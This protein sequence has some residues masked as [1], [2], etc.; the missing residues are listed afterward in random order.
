MTIRVGFFGTGFIAGQ[1]ATRLKDNSGQ[2]GLPETAVV[3]AVSS[4][5]AKAAA[6]LA[7]HGT[8]D[9]IVCS[10]V[11]ELIQAGIDA[12]FVCLPPGI[13]NGEIEAL[14]KAGIHLFL[15]KPLALKRDILHSINKAISDAGVIS[16]VG[17]HYRF[18]DSTRRIIS[19]S[20]N[21]TSGQPVLFDARYWCR[22]EPAT[23]WK[24]S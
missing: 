8:A 9:A 2:N 7:E 6:F 11:D 17:F 1:H 22:F 14:A 21:G 13:R 20:N 10:N 16:Q 3:A 15:E 18:K 12:C 23:W 24:K 19:E 4:D 5:K